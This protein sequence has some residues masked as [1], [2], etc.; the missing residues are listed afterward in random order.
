MATRLRLGSTEAQRSFKVTFYPRS[1]GEIALNGKKLGRKLFFF[2]SFFIA[3][4]YI[5]VITSA[6]NTLGGK[7]QNRGC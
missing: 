3:Q 1:N 6:I 7:K 5:I 2:L 4:N